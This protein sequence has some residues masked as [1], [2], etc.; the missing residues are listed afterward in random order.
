M[1][2]SFGQRFKRKQAAQAALRNGREMAATPES[3]HVQRHELEQDVKAAAALPN[4]ADRVEFKRDV[5]LPKWV[6]VAERYLSGDKVHQNPIFAWCIV[7]LFDVGNFDKALDWADI[8][9]AQGQETPGN[10]KR[11]FSA[12]VADTILEWAQTQHELGHSVEP[13]FGRTFNNVREH[14]RLHEE[15]NAKWFKFAGL[16]RLSDKNGKP[17]PTAID[18]IDTLQAAE[19]LLAQAHA[20]DPKCGVKTTRDKIASRINRLMKEQ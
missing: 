18:D 1:T 8:A 5:L 3:L 16:L 20:F 9:I 10:I 14:W 4:R 19:A 15:I 11:T 7:W 17:T 13:Y 6:P 2:L 12:F